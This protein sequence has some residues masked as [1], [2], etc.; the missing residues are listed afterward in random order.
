[1]SRAGVLQ[2]DRPQVPA[3]GDPAHGQAPADGIPSRQVIQQLIAHLE[4]TMG[5]EPRRVSRSAPQADFQQT[6]ALRRVAGVACQRL[7]LSNDPAV[8]NGAAFQQQPSFSNPR[9]GAASVPGW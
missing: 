1:M 3:D 6:L 7:E 8:V 5:A 2:Q 4:H 9:A